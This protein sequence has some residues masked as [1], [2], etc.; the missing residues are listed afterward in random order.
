MLA[1]VITA[2]ITTAIVRP[3]A[4]SPP[5]DKLLFGLEGDGYI[6]L[7]EPG[8]PDGEYRVPVG[9]RCRMYRLYPKA[10][11]VQLE[12]GKLAYAEYHIILDDTPGNRELFKDMRDAHK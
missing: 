11:V 8:L 10:C 9:A 1:S 2:A 5:F 7:T 6:T 3:R 12:D 4:P